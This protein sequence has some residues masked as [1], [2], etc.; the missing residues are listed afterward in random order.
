MQKLTWQPHNMKDYGMQRGTNCRAGEVDYGMVGSSIRKR[1]RRGRLGAEAPLPS[2]HFASGKWRLTTYFSPPTSHCCLPSGHGQNLRRS[3][4]NCKHFQANQRK[5][6]TRKVATFE[7]PC[8]G[9][10]TIACGFLAFLTTIYQ[11]RKFFKCIYTLF[12]NVRALCTIGNCL[13]SF[14]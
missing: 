13:N 4:K 6:S 2:N 1:P 3:I 11:L 5:N 14:S 8:I 12:S 7:L 9:F 10:T